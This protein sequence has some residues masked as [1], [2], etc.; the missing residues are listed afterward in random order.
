MFSK[1]DYVYAVYQERSFTKAAEKLYISQP[2][3]STAIKNV[4]KMVG[5]PLF[6]RSTTTIKLTEVGKEYIKSAEKI[7]SIRNSFVDKINDI[8]NLEIGKISV[9][10]TNYLT[11][12]VLPRII[13]KFSSRFPKIEV[14]LIEAHSQ[15]LFDRI[16]NEE[17]D[18]V[19]DSFDGVL[20]EYQGYPLLRERVL[21][22]VP[23]DRKINKNLKQFA[24]VPEQIY[25][26]KIN[27]ESIPPVSIE[28]FKDENFVLLKSGND[29]YSRAMKIFNKA[30]VTPK[31]CFSVDQLNISYALAD[32]GMGLSFATDTLFKF[33]KFSSNIILYNIE[34]EHSG[35]TLYIAHKKNKYCTKAMEHFIETAKEVTKLNQI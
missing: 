15:E 24:I 35:R 23:A 27:L 10:G 21:L 28:L 4:E 32:S 9:G 14:D 13:N 6:E 26:D 2:S 8:Y 17:I 3:L 25:N 5:A 29:M 33:G 7:I 12:Y 34:E 18:I 11:S 1:L 22:C 19:I 30:N 16:R 31:I 20:D